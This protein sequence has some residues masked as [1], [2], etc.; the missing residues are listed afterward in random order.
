M[1]SI[2][3]SAN[4]RMAVCLV[5]SRLLTLDAA[6]EF[7]K[8]NA[9]HQVACYVCESEQGNLLAAALTMLGLM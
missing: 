9:T 6:S 3:C 2:T 1:L 5:V 4:N 7:S 8:L